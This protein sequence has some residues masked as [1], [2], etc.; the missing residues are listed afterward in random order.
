MPRNTLNVDI[1]CHGLPKKLAFETLGVQTDL[2]GLILARSVS[3]SLN[4]QSDFCPVTRFWFS[5][6][7]TLIK[8]M[9]L[10]I[11]IFCS[12]SISDF[13]DVTGL[14]GS[15]FCT[16]KVGNYGELSS[17]WLLYHPVIFKA[18]LRI[19]YLIY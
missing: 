3:S 18:R 15:V 7:L 14:D 2:Q 19:A 4:T 11:F 9:K 5:A 10:S 1:V 6:R 8:K 16:T 13:E 17:F 12:Q